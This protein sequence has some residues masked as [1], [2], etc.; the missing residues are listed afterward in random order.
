VFLPQTAGLVGSRL[1][2]WQCFHGQRLDLIQRLGILKC[3]QRATTGFLLQ[4][5]LEIPALLP[6]TLGNGL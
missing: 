6:F 5:W 3:L 2:I 1:A 4:E